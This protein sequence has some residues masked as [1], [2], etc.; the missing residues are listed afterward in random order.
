[1]LAVVHPILKPK[2]PTNRPHLMKR[3]PRRVE[4]EIL[5]SLPATAPEAIRS[6]RDLRL[7]NALMGNHRW[8]RAQVGTCLSGADAPRPLCGW[9]LGA[10]DGSLGASLI[11]RFGEA[12]LK[13][14]ALDLDPR[15]ARWPASWDWQQRDILDTANGSPAKGIVVANLI[16]HHFDDHELAQVGRWA[17]GA[18]S[19]IAVEPLRGR[20]PHALAYAMRLLDINYVT[21]EDIHTSIRAGFSGDELPALLGLDASGW[22]ISTSTTPLGAYRMIARRRPTS[23]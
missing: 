11:E 6:R 4:P 22:D 14:C 1:M 5:D 18:D 16:L 20:F 7:I 10:G 23:R 9:E 2:H 15:A 17:S 3:P 13:I 8:I 12:S 21:R 19:I